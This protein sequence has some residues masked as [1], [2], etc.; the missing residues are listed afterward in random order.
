MGCCS[1]ICLHCGNITEPDAATVD[2]KVSCS[3]CCVTVDVADVSHVG[4]LTWQMPILLMRN[5]RS[6]LS[7]AL[8]VVDVEDD[9]DVADVTPKCCCC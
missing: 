3:C 1:C 8:V 6:P 2:E 9:V 4:E 7:M 5:G